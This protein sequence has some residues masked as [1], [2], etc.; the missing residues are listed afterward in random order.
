MENT[1]DWQPVS[2]IYH[3]PAQKQLWERRPKASGA[4]LDRTGRRSRPAIGGRRMTTTDR[5][6]GWR[7]RD[8]AAPLAGE[9]QRLTRLMD[10]E[11]G[12]GHGDLNVQ[13]HA[14]ERER[15]RGMSW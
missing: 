12:R 15:D 6:R 7:G 10:P 9:F 14:E 8:Q 4:V 1:A 2:Q 3:T 11:D 5:G 13:L